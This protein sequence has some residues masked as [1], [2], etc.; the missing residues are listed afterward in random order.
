LEL[1]TAVAGVGAASVLRV[2]TGSREATAASLVAAA[3]E[4]TAGGMAAALAVAQVVGMEV[5]G[6]E[7]QKAAA[8][9]AMEAGAVAAAATGRWSE[10]HLEAAG[11]LVALEGG[12]AAALRVA[13][14]SKA[15]AV[16]ARVEMEMEA[17][18]V[19]V[20]EGAGWEVAALVA[21]VGMGWEVVALGATSHTEGQ[22]AG[23]DS[24]GVDWVAVAAGRGAWSELSACRVTRPRPMPPRSSMLS[25][26]PEFRP[27]SW[28]QTDR[29]L[30]RSHPP[31]AP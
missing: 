17:V 2:T 19:R 12:P 27:P 15:E 3:V 28:R 25:G 21:L 8:E 16:R 18:V 6:T 14:E 20:L 26:S 13:E 23:A 7:V 4:N 1:A 24:M 9:A 30:Q 29:E 22:A 11:L 10:G 5:A 31:R